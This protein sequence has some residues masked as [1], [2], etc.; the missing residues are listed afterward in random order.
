MNRT[1]KTLAR[2]IVV[3]IACALLVP[4]TALAGRRSPSGKNFTGENPLGVSRAE[5]AAA[6]EGMELIYQRQYSE[7]LQVF[8]EAGIDFPDSPLGPIGRGLVWQAWMY[9]N[10]DF[11]Y[12]RAYLGEYADAKDRLARS[13]R[14]SDDK[15]WIYFLTAV[16]LG[17]DSM[18]DIRKGRHLAAF[19]KAWDALEY[20]KKVE[21]L[22][23]EFHDVQLA[24]GLYN[25]WRTAIS[26]QVD[27]LPSFGD[28]RAEGLAQMQ[29]A[30]DK[31]LLARA[32]ASLVL[33]YSYMEKG[34]FN[35][36]LSE[37]QWVKDRYP[38]NLLN[39]MVMGQ[40]QR[41]LR[42]NSDAVATY[43]YAVDIA[44]DVADTW[45]A[46]ARQLERDRKQL[47]RSRDVYKTYIERST[48]NSRKATGWYRIGMLER[49]LKRYESSK[50]AFAQASQL[51]PSLVKAL[52][53]LAQVTQEQNRAKETRERKRAQRRERYKQLKGKTAT[54]RAATP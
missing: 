10:Y 23:P 31:G 40:V 42:R 20:V 14:R 41:K 37:A 8:E 16:H 21:R 48:D 46:L 26:E 30:K 51:N 49:K 28:H 33:T 34:D 50:Y 4:A 53:R 15:A 29:L 22:A 9:E 6:Q 36:A 1:P 52:E 44:P 45:Y 27:L 12:E 11:T 5:F 38:N 3:A 47:K 13:S 54:T 32:P 18:Y 7:A 19:D 17:L 24:L 35:A 25:Y 43:E 39:L 2:F